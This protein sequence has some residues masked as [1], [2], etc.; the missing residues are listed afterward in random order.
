MRNFESA[1]TAAAH[2]RVLSPPTSELF[3]AVGASQAAAGD[4]EGAIPNLE[5][6]MEA[7]PDS[8]ET[9]YNLGLAWLRSGHPDK[10]APLINALAKREENAEV[11]DLLGE[12]DERLGLAIDAVRA[13]QKA[14]E[15][16][17]GN[18]DY[19]FDYVSE[20]LAHKS[21]DAAILVARAAA[22]KLPSSLKL[23]LALCGALYGNGNV[24]EAHGVA[25]DASQ[26][27]PESNLPLYLRNVIA[28]AGGNP[29]TSL[30]AQTKTYLEGHPKDATGWLILGQAEARQGE[31][32][33]AMDSL[34]RSLAIKEESAEAH[35]A[36]SRIY[37]DEGK[38]QQ[39]VSH[40]RRAIELGLTSA[41]VRYRLSQALY[42]LGRKSEG[43]LEMKSYRDAHRV[44]EEKKSAV[45]T[46]VY[47]LR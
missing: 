4:Y 29:D 18:E 23:Q 32:A 5:E 45:A 37:F 17:P 8:N 3:R 16:D 28:D 20:L 34:N 36:I 12:I 14:A 26:K 21:F 41:V 27:F 2:L 42:R 1:R 22:D 35:F 44:E 31:P 11:E 40:S 33:E 25:V 19:A 30:L 43:D 24:E 13:F 39:V 38:W 46:F 7:S 15:L 47:T 6:A 9:A 10:A